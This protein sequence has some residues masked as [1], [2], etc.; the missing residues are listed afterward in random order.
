MRGRQINDEA[1]LAGVFTSGNADRI[2]KISEEGRRRERTD[3]KTFRN[4]FGQIHDSRAQDP[5]SP[6]M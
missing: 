2:D 6:N 1:F 3:H 4:F 5:G